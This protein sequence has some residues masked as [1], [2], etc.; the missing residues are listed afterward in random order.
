MV[1]PC[2]VEPLVEAMTALGRDPGLRLETA[3]RGYQLAH[4]EFSV[5]SVCRKVADLYECA[6]G[7]SVRPS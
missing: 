2:S 5:E 6:A 4:Q 3:C 7:A 1:T